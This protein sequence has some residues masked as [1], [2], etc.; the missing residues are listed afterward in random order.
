MHYTLYVYIHVCV[1]TVQGFIQD[2]LLEAGE[3]V[4]AMFQHPPGKYF[5]FS[6]SEVDFSTIL[7]CVHVYTA[8]HNF[9]ETEN[10]NPSLVS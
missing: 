3:K 4:L 5:S 1:Y 10:P 8:M 9:R 2:L 6:F 7:I